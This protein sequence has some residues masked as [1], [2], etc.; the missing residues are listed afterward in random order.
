MLYRHDVNS[1]SSGIQIQDYVNTPPH[2][3]LWSSDVP[4]YLVYL[5]NFIRTFLLSS[6]FYSIQ[7]FCKQTTKSLIR[8]HKCA[9]LSGTLLS[10]YTPKN[11]FFMTC[12]YNTVAARF[13]NQ[14]IRNYPRESMPL[15]TKLKI[16]L[17][18]KHI[19]HL[20]LLY[21]WRNRH[22]NLLGLHRCTLIILTTRTP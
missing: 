4:D 10:E 5:C 7:Q 17:G 20:I 2:L 12:S 18:P 13:L 11:P 22:M 15:H 19:R 14:I 21:G 3:E 16:L 9:V 1:A 8:L 6:I